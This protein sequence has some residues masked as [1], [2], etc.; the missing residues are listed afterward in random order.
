M[1]YRVSFRVS[2]NRTP[3]ITLTYTTSYLMSSPTN[4]GEQPNLISLVRQSRK[5]LQQ[6]EALCSRA[7]ATST[8]SAREATDVLALNAK[9]QW[10]SNAV[11][12]QLKARSTSNFDCTPSS[13]VHSSQ[14]RWQS[15]S[16]SAVQSSRNRLRHVSLNLHTCLL[17]YI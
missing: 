7:N 10:I 8:S 9:I 6:G 17:T 16:R 4:R 3:S 15:S 1:Y 5:A 12:E 2:L 14:L 11:I 13:H